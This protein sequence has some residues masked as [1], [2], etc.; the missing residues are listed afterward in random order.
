MTAKAIKESP[1]LI[2]FILLALFFGL[3]GCSRSPFQCCGKIKRIEKVRN[4]LTDEPAAYVAVEDSSGTL[5]QLGLVKGI[6]D[7]G[8]WVCGHEQ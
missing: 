4:Q 6:L 1:F 2:A 8:D 3:H 5:R 7:E